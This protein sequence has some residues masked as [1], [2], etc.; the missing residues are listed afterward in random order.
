V[1]KNGKQ[2][3]LTPD[4]IRILKGIANDRGTGGAE[5]DD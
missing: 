2:Y 3:V 1:T 5:N 4:G